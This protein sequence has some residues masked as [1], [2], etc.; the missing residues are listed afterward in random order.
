[1]SKIV[2]R[3]ECTILVNLD[4]SVVVKQALGMTVPDCG[5]AFPQPLVLRQ[6]NTQYFTE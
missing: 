5:F 4:E 1:M 6:P 2:G 3:K